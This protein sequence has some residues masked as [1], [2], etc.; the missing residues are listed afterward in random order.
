[1]RNDPFVPAGLMDGIGETAVDE[2]IILSLNTF[3]NI[4][5]SGYI[6]SQRLLQ[7]KHNDSARSP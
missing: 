3:D 7:V 6:V 5:L 2:Y 4:Y 1:M